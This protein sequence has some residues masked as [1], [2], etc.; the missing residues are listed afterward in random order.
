MCERHPACGSEIEKGC[1]FCQIA[2]NSKESS[3]IAEYPNT[4]VIV[5]LEGN[6]L[7][8]TRH[9]VENYLDPNLDDE[10]AAEL[11]VVQKKIAQAMRDS[12]QNADINIISNNGSESG[13]DIMHLH[14]HLISRLKNDEVVRFNPVPINDREKL[15]TIAQT[16]R[17]R[18]QQQ[19]HSPAS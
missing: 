14:I 19:G 2:Q 4:L 7:I 10:T 3:V 6:P 8:I 16:I 15:E 9:H 1:V 12:S 17:L 11:G 13:Q 5:S 18:L